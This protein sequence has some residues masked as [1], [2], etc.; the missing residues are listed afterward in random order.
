MAKSISINT[1]VGLREYAIL[2]AYLRQ[3]GLKPSTHSKV[4]A[5]LLS[6]TAGSIEKNNG[7]TFLDDDAASDFLERVGLPVKIRGEAKKTAPETSAIDAAVLSLG[8]VVPDE[9]TL[10]S[11]NPAD[12]IEAAKKFLNSDF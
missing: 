7:Q 5:L 4:I 6:R 1:T 12:L 3:S 10:E 11:H 9:E 2:V 8:K